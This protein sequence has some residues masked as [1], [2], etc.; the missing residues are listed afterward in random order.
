MNFPA[1][2]DGGVALADVTKASSTEAAIRN[3][4]FFPLM[5]I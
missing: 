1:Q 3:L 2:L 4:I 5:I